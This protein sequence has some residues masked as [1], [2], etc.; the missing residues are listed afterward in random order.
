MNGWNEMKWNEMACQYFSWS[1]GG[2]L[3]SNSKKVKIFPEITSMAFLILIRVL[4]FLLFPFAS[5]FII[6]IMLC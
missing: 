3:P 5:L 4:L 1:G 2:G 6:I